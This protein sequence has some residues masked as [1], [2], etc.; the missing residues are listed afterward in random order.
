V[1][2]RKQGVNL[3]NNRPDL[4]QLTIKF[5]F[6]D[7]VSETIKNKKKEVMIQSFLQNFKD[8]PSWSV[9]KHFF[10]RDTVFI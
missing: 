7:K 6:N 10:R 1:L 2:G 3:R 9:Y 5:I 4:P 8:L